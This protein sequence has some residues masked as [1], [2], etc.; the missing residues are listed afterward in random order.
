MSILLIKI[1]LIAIDYK[2]IVSIAEQ[3]FYYLKNI[4]C[5][6]VD[7][8]SL[9]LSFEFSSNYHSLFLKKFKSREEF[10]QEYSICSLFTYNLE[11]IYYIAIVNSNHSDNLINEEEDFFMSM[12]IEYITN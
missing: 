5:K 2:S 3:I 8:I 11:D 12:K 10:L 1:L 7:I 6:E 4:I 9:L